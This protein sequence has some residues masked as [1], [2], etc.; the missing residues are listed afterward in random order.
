MCRAEGQ[1]NAEHVIRNAFH[2]FQYEKALPEVEKKIEKL[3][4]EAAMLDASGESDVAEYH[5]LRLDLVLL[6]KNMMSEIMRP[7]RVL[8]Y[9]LPGR[10]VKIR[11]G[12]TDWGWGVVVNVVKKPPATSGTVPRGGGYIVDT[13]PHCS[14]GTSENGSRPKP[15]PL[16]LGRRVKCMWFDERRS[17]LERND[18]A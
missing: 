1:F 17:R 2:Q 6:E 16:V 4:Q 15:C 9:L 11:E 7:E 18:V 3:E 14:P 5:K 12:G 13:L 10:L 8:Y